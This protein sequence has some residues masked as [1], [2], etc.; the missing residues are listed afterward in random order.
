MKSYSV[1][2]PSLNLVV[3]HP[4]LLI[5]TFFGSGCLTPA[6]GT[7]GSIA[8]WLAFLV[9]SKFIDRSCLWLL[10][11]LL[12]FLGVHAV[13][14]SYKYLKKMDHGSIVVDEVVAVWFSLLL[15]PI[16]FMWQLLT[17]LL[18]RFFDIV[19]LPPASTIDSKEQN[20]WTVMIDDI[21]AALY[22]VLIIDLIALIIQFSVGT[23]ISWGFY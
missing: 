5:S 2:P 18:F 6:P 4:W 9:L 1:K 20:G 19:K 13:N 12:F 16:G 22:T 14:K 15:I 7:W 17:V 11:I 10:T 8:A 3:H 21:F 23:L